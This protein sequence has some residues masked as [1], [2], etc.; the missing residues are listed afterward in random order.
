MPQTIL[1]ITNARLQPAQFPADA[2]LANGQY[3][4]SK[5]FLPGMCIGRKTSDG[6]LYPA[7]SVN[8]V[9]TVSFGAVAAA[10][11][12]FTIS[13][14]TSA[15]IVGT[16]TALAFN[17]SIATIQT[18]LDVASG[19][20]NGVVASSAGTAAPASTPTPLILTFSGTGYANLQQP[21]VDIN[22]QL[23]GGPINANQLLTAG[24]VVIVPAVANVPPNQIQQVT[25]NINASA[26]AIIIAIT[27]PSGIIGYA[28]PIAYNASIATI[29]TALDLASGVANGVVASSAGSV[30]PFSNATPLI[31]TF[32][33]TGFANTIWPLVL[34]EADSTLA[35]TTKITV[36]DTTV[37]RDGTDVCIGFVEYGFLTDANSKC[38]LTTVSP[39]PDMVVTGLATLPYYTNG[40]FLI[41]DLIGWNNSFLA[42]LNGR[43][44]SSTLVRIP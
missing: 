32:S 5:T 36:Q 35:G 15:G 6:L 3:G 44:L 28:G 17:A 4:A 41:A 43:L 26:G 1:T 38:Y 7:S 27:R 30:A 31:L 12:A 40:V 19:V 16:T 18:A 29:Q 11:G 37:T 2:R 14:L 39:N 22:K 42:Q 24:N 9:Q 33:G 23:I 34:I 13:L 10:S 20:A 25:T 21:L 8:D